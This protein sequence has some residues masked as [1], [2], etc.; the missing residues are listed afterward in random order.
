MNNSWPLESLYL[1]QY[2]HNR[3]DVVAIHRA[4]IP[5]PE[6]LEQVTP[7]LPDQQRLKPARQMLYGSAQRPVAQAVPNCVLE[8]VVPCVGAQLHQM[9]AQ[10]AV[11]V[12]D[13]VVIV[14]ENDQQIGFR[15]TRIVEPLKRQP[16]RQRTVSHQR[17]HLP[18]AAGNP[19]RLS[20]TESR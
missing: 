10:T 9:V 19:L 15:V 20:H 12:V 4:E 14:I 5:E 3:P 17:N 16:A 7:A 18:A 2:L 13:G 8:F 1:L 6:S 11:N